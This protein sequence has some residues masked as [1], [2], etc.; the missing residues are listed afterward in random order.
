MEQEERI[1]IMQ[2]GIVT[3][4][5]HSAYWDIQQLPPRTGPTELPNIPQVNNTIVG[6][7]NATNGP[8]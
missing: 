1:I 3:R 6:N 2:I 4:G 5:P 7:G 8:G